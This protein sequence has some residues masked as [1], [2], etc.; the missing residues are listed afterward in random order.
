MKTPLDTEVD[1]SPG[2]I[3]SDGD[4]APPPQRGTAFILSVVVR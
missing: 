2:H 4:I 3:V 1:L